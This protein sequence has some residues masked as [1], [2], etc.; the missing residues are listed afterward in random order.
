MGNKVSVYE[1]VE[2]LQEHISNK[3]KPKEL[4]MILKNLYSKIETHKTEAIVQLNKA[5]G[6]RVY[7]N[8]PH[9]TNSSRFGTPL[10][11][12]C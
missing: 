9:S 6:R 11:K 1:D 12:F 7:Y 8:G 5:V 4:N 10:R 3:A 2:E